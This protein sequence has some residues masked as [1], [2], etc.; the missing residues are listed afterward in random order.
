MNWTTVCRA[1]QENIDPNFLYSS[2][3]L[4]IA[5]LLCSTLFSGLWLNRW[6][7]V[8]CSDPELLLSVWR[9]TGHFLFLSFFSGVFGTAAWIS[10][11]IQIPGTMLS[12]RA[13]NSTTCQEELMAA[14]QGNKGQS[15][16]RICYSLEIGCL[17]LSIILG[18][19]RISE[20]AL[21]AKS[22]S[23]QT[24]PAQRELPSDPNV[25]GRSLTHASNAGAKRGQLELL[26]PAAASRLSSGRSSEAESGRTRAL[27]LLFRAGL[28]VVAIGFI[29]AFISIMIAA[30]YSAQ[31][32]SLYQSAYNEC[33]PNGTPSEASEKLQNSVT[34]SRDS[35]RNSIFVGYLCEFV[36][37]IVVILL[38]VVAG[39]LGVSIVSSARNTIERS[40]V[41]LRQ[42]QFINAHEAKA[43]SA[44]ASRL[45]LFSRLFAA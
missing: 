45:L 19:D 24:A 20:H 39:C 2:Q 31:I 7:I 34:G 3:G 33:N 22:L 25:A 10:K 5:C 13:D 14:I 1:S 17:I 6:R 40:L 15:A 36:A 32:G 21:N 27:Q 41:K 8:K 28:A 35:Q 38:Y 12:L 42:L 30:S 44:G 16:F 29:A 11:L 23:K 43:A 18:L 37:A 26:L 9:F 4:A